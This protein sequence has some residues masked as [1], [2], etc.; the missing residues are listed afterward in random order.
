MTEAVGFVK[1][2]PEGYVFGRPTKYRTEFCERVIEMGKQGY[3]KNEMACELGVTKVTLLEWAKE[4]DD[5]SYAFT[6]AQEESQTWWERQGRTNLET[7]GFQSSMWGRNMGA[8]FPD[9]WREASKQEVSGP[10]GTPLVP[11]L[12]VTVGRDQSESSS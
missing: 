8:R 5:F 10:G 9:E 11:V 12:N 7:P 6:R 3:S 1:E 4:K 2:K